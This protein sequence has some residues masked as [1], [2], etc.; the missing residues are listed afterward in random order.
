MHSMIFVAGLFAILLAIVL[1]LLKR[2]TFAQYRR[3]QGTVTELIERPSHTDDRQDVKFTPRIA[4][5]TAQG[6]DVNFT[7]RAAFFGRLQVGDTLP[8]LHEP[9]NPQNAVIDGFFHRHL[10]ELVVF[11]LGLAAVVPYVLH[12]FA[13]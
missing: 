10:T 3:V 9:K 2:A 11:L 6:A 13:G 7:P 1:F 5:R 8:L 4:F 12:K